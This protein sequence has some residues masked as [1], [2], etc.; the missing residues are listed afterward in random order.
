MKKLEQAGGRQSLRIAISQDRYLQKCNWEAIPSVHKFEE[1]SN[2][3]QDA[4]SHLHSSNSSSRLD[5]MTGDR[6]IKDNELPNRSNRLKQIS[7]THLLVAALIATVTFTAGFTAP[8]GNTGQTSSQETAVLT[9][10]V[11]FKV[12]LIANGLAFYCSTVSAFLHFLASAEQNYHLLLRFMRSAAVLTYISILSL[13]IAFTS[14]MH[15]ILPEHSGFSKAI[16][17]LGCCYL[18][19]C[20]FGFI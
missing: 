14:G 15:V 4:S 7:G 18:A 10:K 1:F 9:S 19:F 12:F 6:N 13:V 5:D 16:L 3:K 20:L 11:A 8:G 2:S 17:V